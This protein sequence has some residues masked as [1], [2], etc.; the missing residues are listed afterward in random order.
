M[1]STDACAI[2]FAVPKLDA[3]ASDPIDP[4]TSAVVRFRA[5]EEAA[6]EELV[7]RREGDVYRLARRML[8]DA[9]DALEATQDVFLRAYRAL[10][11]FRGEASFRTWLLGIAVNVCRSRLSGRAARDKRRNVPLEAADREDGELAFGLPA[12]PGPDPERRAQGAE[13]A[14]ALERALAGL[15][16]EHR[17][18]LLLREM[19][20]LEYEELA[21]TLECAVGTVKSRLARAR[22]ALRAAMEV[23]WP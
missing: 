6:F 8:G 7:S 5:G 10:P 16:P 19:E 9:D 12:A 21:S 20:G 3:L 22:G 23:L 18:I 4:E 13:L 14:A 15:S 11:R 17:E 2:L 1:S